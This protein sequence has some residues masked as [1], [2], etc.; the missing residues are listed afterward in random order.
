MRVARGDLAKK[1]MPVAV[2]TLISASIVMLYPP[3]SLLVILALV[4]LISLI[5][6]LVV[7]VFTTHKYAALTSVFVFIMLILRALDLFDPINITLAISLLV[8]VAIL[9]K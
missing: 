7:K 2:L 1:F 4:S 6:G 3:T 9:I 8:G 5:I